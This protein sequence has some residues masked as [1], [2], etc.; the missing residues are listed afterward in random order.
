MNKYLVSLNELPPSG[1]EFKI[2]DQEVWKE[3][4]KEFKMDCSITEPLKMDVFVMNAEDG[5]LVRGKLKGAV[6]VPCNRCMENANIII[7]SEFDEYEEIPENQRHKTDSEH[8]VFERG[9][10]MLN[11]A[12]VGWEQFM[13]ALPQSPLC[14]EDCKGLCGKCGAN[15][16]AGDCG[17]D[18]SPQDERMAVLRNLKIE[19]K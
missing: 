19:K 17:C 1:K 12:E 6:T 13:L 18:K 14:R 8:I 11:L 3:P 2:D 4:I 5:C 15:L 16:N 7:D 10:P 9:V